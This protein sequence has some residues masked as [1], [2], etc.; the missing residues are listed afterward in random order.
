MYLDTHIEQHKPKK[1]VEFERR[2]TREVLDVAHALSRIDRVRDLSSGIAL[3]RE[4]A[5]QAPVVEEEYVA[6]LEQGRHARRIV[7]AAVRRR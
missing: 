7:A 1:S 3:V 6:R 2:S 4:A 5:V